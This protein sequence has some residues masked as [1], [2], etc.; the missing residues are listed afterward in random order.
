MPILICERQLNFDQVVRDTEATTRDKYGA[1]GGRPI[2]TILGGLHLLN[3]TP[4]LVDKTIA[5]FRR[6]DVQRLS[7]L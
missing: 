5:A 1:T 6:F 4:E 3:A 7:A 2:H